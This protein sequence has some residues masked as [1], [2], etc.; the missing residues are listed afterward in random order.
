MTEDVDVY[1]A[2]LEANRK[3]HAVALATVT[4]TEGSTPG[5]IGFK[6]LV[7]EDGKILGTVGGGENESIV[8]AEALDAIRT[9]QARLKTV[10]YGGRGVGADEPI[11]G[12]SSDIFIEPIL[13]S[14]TLYIFGAGHVGQALAKLAK[15]VGL[16]V[17]I[18][19]D[20]VEFANKERFPEADVVL[21]TDYKDA[22]EKLKLFP[23][24][25]VVIVTHGH[26][27]DFEVLKSFVECDL[28]YIG[29]IGSRKKVEEIFKALEK[30]GVPE[31]LLKKVHAPIGMDIGA[32]TPAE[33]AV[34]IMAEIVSTM[35]ATHQPGSSENP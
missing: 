11:C 27:N 26:K 19:D 16:R 13:P 28:N 17:V 30:D 31:R 4:R 24:A 9:A 29:M 35:R 23:N 34:S 6:M 1:Q 33:I 2:I 20:R 21:V 22:K 7:F 15:I 18:I 12:G 8:V 14:A 32:E 25:Y 10:E 5:R 3:G